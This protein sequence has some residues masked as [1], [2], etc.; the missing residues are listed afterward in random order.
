MEQKKDMNQ[1]QSRSNGQNPQG[2]NKLEQYR[3]FS[4]IMRK[5]EKLTTALYLVTDILSEK[6]PLK[7]KAREI[8]VEVLSD[9]TI[10]STASTSEKMSMLREVMK[11]IE[12]VIAFLDVA[13][14]AR[15]MTDMNASML[16]KEYVALKDNIEAEWSRV[17][18]RSKT[19]LTERF[20]DV[21]VEMIKEPKE[22]VLEERKTTDT[23]SLRTEPK[24]IERTFTLMPKSEPQPAPQMNRTE[25][26]KEVRPIVTPDVPKFVPR[27]PDQSIA[28]VADTRTEIAK[29]DAPRQIMRMPETQMRTT[30]SMNDRLPAVPAAQPKPTLSIADSFSRARPDVARDD[31]RT[32]ILAL[33]KQKPAVTVGDIAKSIPGVSEKT[34]Q[35]ELLSMVAEGVLIKRGERRWSTYSVA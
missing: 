35:R 4:Y 16:K 32:I 8:G 12:K 10:S 31:R 11:K 13:Q 18:E 26:R 9:V 25:E 29:N 6:E 22:A 21:P 20:F 7:W 5:A 33:L 24:D 14:S 2:Q 30:V 34:I 3:G 23:A 17:H 27:E 1:D 28:R 19:I 15:M